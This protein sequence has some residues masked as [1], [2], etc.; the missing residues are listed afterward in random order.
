MKNSSIVRELDFETQRLLSNKNDV[1][2]YEK[3]QK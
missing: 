1:S 2:I 3:N